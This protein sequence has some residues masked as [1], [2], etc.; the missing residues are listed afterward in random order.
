MGARKGREIN[1][2]QNF[3]QVKKSGANFRPPTPPGGAGPVCI[4]SAV[5]I[6]S[7]SLFEKARNK[8]LEHITHAIVAQAIGSQ[9]D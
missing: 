2:I 9:G 7:C 1:F 8:G 5:T 4:I 6:T 3:S